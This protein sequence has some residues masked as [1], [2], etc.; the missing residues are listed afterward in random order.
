[1]VR[2]KPRGGDFRIIGLLSAGFAILVCL[3]LAT[4]F[5]A[6]QAIEASERN[7]S[8]LMLE[9][10][11][12]IRVMNELQR[13]EDALSGVFYALVGRPDARQRAEL[14][15]QVD[16]LSSRV[17]A[18]T[19][20]GLA[21]GNH[22]DWLKVRTAATE[23]ITE[24]RR[25]LIEEDA[26]SEVLNARH[27]ELI[28]VLSEI[29]TERYQEAVEGQTRQAART[30]TRVRNM[31]VLLMV[32][33]GIA[34]PGAVLAVRAAVRMLRTLEWQ[35]QELARLTARTMSVQEETARRFSRELHDQF[36]QT[37]TA[38]EANLVAL[39]DAGG[40]PARVADCL[41]LVKDAMANVREISQLLR[42][43][44]LDDFGLD[45]SLRWLAETFSQRTGVR[46]QY[47]STFEGRLSGEVETQLFRIAQEALTNV[48]RHSE[49]TRVRV[50]LAAGAGRL[51]L[52]IADNGHG[53]P[54]RKSEMSTGLISMRTRARETGGTLSIRSAPG[55]GVTITVEL[56]LQAEKDHAA[57]DP[58]LV[59]R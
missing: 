5:V 17:H 57:E 54:E 55:K 6:Y 45:A 7:N 4:A 21:L 43:S 35:T 15:K 46:V 30:R 34:I 58:H 38:I 37:L 20:A 11:A 3:L 36:G 52:T 28:D 33:I 13:E 31:L 48:A 39:R 29:S 44:V 16:I 8:R 50:D 1:V 18:S 59:G 42:P 40:N 32:A 19:E 53:L 26:P 22:E 56:P 27:Q 25:T 51:V 9:Q 14:L 12:N 10:N 24:V 47:T 23:F 2:F 49:A 41:T